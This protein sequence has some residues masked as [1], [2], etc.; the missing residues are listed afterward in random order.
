MRF[1]YWLPMF[2]GWLRNVE[3]EG[4]EA[5]WDYVSRLARRSEEI[6]FDLTLL[7]ELNL[8][9]IKGMEAPSLDAW[10][11]AAALAAV[12]RRLEIM[13]AVRPTFHE[14]ALLAKQ[15]ANIDRISGGRLS[16]N[17]VSSW[18]ATEARKY[19]I[20]FDRHDERY[21]RTAEWLQVVK[22]LWTRPEFSFDGEYYQIE[23][24]LLEPKPLQRP[25]PTLYAG[26]ESPAGRSVISEHCDAWL[27]HGDPPE[28]IAPKLADLRRRRQDLGL[29]PLRFGAAGYVVVRSTEAEVRR[30]VERITN[31]RQSARGF[32]NYQDWVQNTKMDRTVSLEDYSVSNRGLR[33]GLVGTPEQVADRIRELEG[34][35]LDLLLLQFSPQHEEMERFAEEVIPLVQEVHAV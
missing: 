10:S 33:S 16:L 4:M 27:T 35:G 12:T 8:N 2:G 20:R 14:P 18:W 34:V 15:A 7:A 23:D 26:G 9:D 6:G 11:T 24:G 29:P 13:V 19:G 3:D 30:E 17:V 22:G 5:S 21:A 32:A 28:D 25:H 31:V 1:G